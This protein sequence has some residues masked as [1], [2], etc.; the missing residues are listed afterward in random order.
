MQIERVIGGMCG[1]TTQQAIG[2]RMR[3]GGQ[4]L[5]SGTSLV[6]YD[7]A[8]LN[9]ITL[10]TFGANVADGTAG[11]RVL[12]TTPKFSLGNGPTPDFTLTNTIPA[13][14]LAAGRLAFQQ[15]STV[16]WSVS[17]GGAAYTGTNTGVTIAGGGNDADGNFGPPFA[18]A[19]PSSS[20]EALVFDGVATDP[21]TSN[22]ADYVETTGGATFANNAG[23]SAAALVC[24]QF[25][26]GFESG[27]LS[28]WA[29]AEP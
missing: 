1:D 8:G 4:N 29:T 19:L 3:F 5:V 23:T 6:A 25:L 17:W 28:A 16:W 18:G 12:I 24:I 20:V 7:A 13:S 14:Y 21:S 15:G 10:I 22:L 9:P 26:D 2:L 27:D 11:S